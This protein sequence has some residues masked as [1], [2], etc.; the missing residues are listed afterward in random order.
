MATIGI[1]QLGPEVEQF[2]ERIMPRRTRRLRVPVAQALEILTQQEIDRLLDIDAV[3]QAAIRRCEQTG[4]VFLDEMDKICG[5][6]GGEF[7]GPEVSRSGVQ[8]DLLPLV[9]GTAVSTRYGLVRTDHVLFIAAGAFTHSRPSD[10]MPELQGR[11]PIRVELEALTADDYYRIL[12][13]PQNAL[14]K[15]QVALLKTEGV[16]LNFTDEAIREMAQ[17]AARANEVLENIGARRLHTILEKVLEEIAF[18]ASDAGNKDVM[19]DVDYVRLRLAGILDD[20]E[21]RE[22]EF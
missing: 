3:H 5:S 18:L 16:S 7:S 2:F 15:Q 12:T 1:D 21:R 6:P 11:F 17:M 9:E 20:E 13:E 14:I 4:L 8:R 19:V 10:L 22:F